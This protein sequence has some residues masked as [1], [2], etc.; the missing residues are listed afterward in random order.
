MLN[1]AHIVIVTPHQAGIY[2]TAYDLILAERKLGLNAF[3]IDPSQKYMDREVPIGFVNF[4][5]IDIIIN[6]SGLGIFEKIIIDKKI[7]II[8][9]MHGR[10]DSSFRLEFN[11]K[12]GV[13][14]YLDETIKIDNYKYWITFWKEYL[15]YWKMILPENRVLALNSPVN[16]DFWTPNGPNG[17]K[18][19]NMAGKINIVCTDMWRD[20]ITPFHIIH[21]FYE[22]VKLNSGLNIKLH[23]YGLDKNK[24]IYNIL[25]KKLKQNNLLGENTGIVK[26]LDNVYRAAT[27]TISP[28]RIATRAIRE[29]MAC[30]CPVVAPAIQFCNMNISSAIIEDPIWFGNYMNEQFKFYKGFDKESRLN[31]RKYA[32]KNYNSLDTAKIILALIK[33]VLKKC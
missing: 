26:G 30:G 32:E 21:G 9:C 31:A 23:L 15:P 17:Y 12:S 4:D 14:S 7:P 22:F 18:F 13:Y 2:E 29:S 24:K 11:N 16:L 10:P 5:K 20:D 27:F 25:F 1:I 3:I 28:H 6:H 19:N 8:H 33:K